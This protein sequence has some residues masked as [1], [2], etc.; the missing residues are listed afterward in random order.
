MYLLCVYTQRQYAI[1]YIQYQS[2]HNLSCFFITTLQI[3]TDDV[4]SLEFWCLHNS[5]VNV[6]RLL[7]IKMCFIPSVKW[8]R[9]EDWRETD[10]QFSGVALSGC[11]NQTQS[12]SWLACP[13]GR[14]GG[15][16]SE[17]SESARCCA[18]TQR[19]LGHKASARTNPHSQEVCWMDRG[20]SVENKSPMTADVRRSPTTK[21]SSANTVC[22]CVF[23]EGFGWFRR[24]L[25]ASAPDSPYIFLEVPPSRQ[26][27]MPRISTC[28]CENK[29]EEKTEKILNWVYL[30]PA[31]F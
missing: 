14:D 31:P 15:Q 16:C 28:L 5:H 7:H 2:G 23:L 24:W 9:S 29:V 26:H 6:R 21:P 20:A 1:I 12:A 18:N 13:E 27:K 10:G 30:H 3:D 17:V 4:V 22:C 19:C 8:F 11:R 25:E